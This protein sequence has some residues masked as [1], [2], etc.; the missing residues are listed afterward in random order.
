MQFDPIRRTESGTDAVRAGQHWMNAIWLAVLVGGLYVLTAKLSL[1]LLTPEGV[2]VFWPAAG[3]AAGALI[4]LG[5]SA[6]WP[7]AFGT[8]AATI[9]A[10]LLGDR[11]LWSTLI[12]AFCNAGEAVLA[13]YLVERYFGPDFSLNKLP[14][15]LGLL[16]AAII[17]AAASGVGGALGFALFHDPAGSLLVIWRNWF[18][19]DGLGIITIAPLVIGL[20]WAAREPPP[21]NETIEGLL[22]LAVLFVVIAVAI[23]LPPAHWKTIVPVALL[24]PLLLWIASRCRPVFAAGAAFLI[25]MAIVW[26][27]T[28]GINHFGYPDLPMGQRVL[29]AQV[30][31]LAVALCAYVLA[32]LF[33][34]RRQNEAALTDSEARLQEALKA[35]SVTAFAWDVGEE[36]SARS[37]NA[38]QVLGFDPR[39]GFTVCEFLS[40]VHPE[41]RERF[42]Q[43]VQDARPEN[44]GYTITFRF[45]RPDGKDIWLEETARVEFS[46]LGRRTRLQGLTLDVTDRK[47]SERTQ[48]LLIEEV[49]RHIQ[50]LLAQVAG[51]ATQSHRAGGDPSQA[52]SGRIQSMADVHS[53]LSRNRWQDV[54]LTE[55]LRRLL[56]AHASD[57]NA[58]I[59]GPPVKLSA[60]AAQT[61]AM[62]FHELVTN[63]AKYGALSSPHGR[64]EV[65]WRDGTGEGD[66]TLSIVWRE[67]RGPKI[68]AVP[69][70]GY[71]VGLV[72][73]LIPRELGGRV[74]FDFG[75]DGLCCKFDIPLAAL[76][77]GPSVAP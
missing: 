59:G 52:L 41:D 45:K 35:G 32:A 18:A 71:G 15:V 10:N 9:V 33:A 51:V 40:R 12:F 7:V 75:A 6:R 60:A 50:K 42:K 74:D 36:T 16:G 11:N 58:L 48:S 38:A 23:F 39:R 26:T 56:S 13:A 66:P 72:R 28:V 61:L 25:A 20:A 37:A 55:L 22:A 69:F 65:N 54:D 30:G 57:A 77:E 5:P 46:P 62:A 47:Q 8:A 44:P 29:V 17:A 70:D 53:L 4:A 14:N 34:E 2:A 1:S 49:D 24:F 76:R 3:I 31:I 73:E 27:T 68:A 64:V 67:I 19:S 63:A 43:I 21:R